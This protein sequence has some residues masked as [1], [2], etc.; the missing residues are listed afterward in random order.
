[1]L[2]SLKIYPLLCFLEKLFHQVFSRKLGLSAIAQIGLSFFINA[3][4]P[5]PVGTWQTHFNY[6]RAVDVAI[7][8]NIVYC[9][10]QEGLFYYDQSAEEATKLTKIDGLSENQIAVIEYQATL[11]LLVIG[12]QSGGIDLVSLNTQHEPSSITT[13]D[14]IKE[15]NT[16]QSSKKVT[17]IVFNNTRAYLAYS[18][19]LVVLDL[20]KKDIQET[21]LY[22]GEGGTP[23]GVL[24]TA[25]LNDSIFVNTSQGIRAASL[26]SDINLQYFG[27][28]HTLTP[29][30]GVSS[31]IGN[32]LLFGTNNGDILTYNNGQ[33]TTLLKLTSA[34]DKLIPL[35]EQSFL[36]LANKIIRQF[37]LSD[38][39][40]R[41]LSEKLIQSPQN[42]VL[43]AQKK[44]WI[45]DNTNGI[46]SNYTGV[47]KSYS[48]TS[49][50]TLYRTRKD[51]IIIDTEGNRWTRLGAFRGILVE[52]AQKQQ[53]YIYSGQGMGN[54]PSSTVVS[55][56]TDKIGQIW[57]GTTAGV[58]VFDN[59]SAVFSGRNFDAYTPIFEKRRLLS[60]E[61]VTAIAVDGGNR[62][63]I[64]TNNGLFLFSDDGTS[65]VNNF[66]E[67]NS[68]LPSNQIQYIT[69]NGQSGEV[70]IRTNKGMV[71]YRG[72]ATDAE[73]TQGNNVKVFP[74]PVK[75][76]FEGLVSI[77]G[78]VENA[79]VKI[80]DAAGRLIY[81]TRANGGTAVWNA[82]TLSG[83]RASTGIYLVFSSNTQGNEAL[84]SKIAIVQ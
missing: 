27:N 5:I 24:Q 14:F 7:A 66:T 64:G 60:N 31:F 15:N 74:N 21:Y 51:S 28:W 75:P 41:T 13:I 50:D 11:Q 26:R 76:D 37:D 48:P 53:I 56:A 73:T 6:T 62:K 38:N 43:D 78:L 77:E 25:V 47:F 1:M 46:I 22:L 70:F 65:L 39:S 30:Q 54:L 81:E 44:Y 82:K 36:I 71:S 35:G 61:T 45:A 12:Y 52:N 3:Q 4:N 79:F 68:P 72:T 32:K 10:T 20:V 34:I 55:M 19:G 42:A 29:L 8:S 80:T 2:S 57:A 58:A 69:V 84:V 9:A 40:V 16:I 18:F 49:L 67:K 33:F 83:S 23:L 59:P 63:W 17:D